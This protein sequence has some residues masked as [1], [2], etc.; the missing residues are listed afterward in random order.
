MGLCGLGVMLGYQYRLSIGLFTVLWTITY[1]MQKSAY[2]NH[3]YLL[4]I[5]SFLMV[6]QFLTYAEY[7]LEFYVLYINSRKLHVLY[8]VDTAQ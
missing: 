2:N 6:Y 1:L 7:A 4:F 8:P 3:Y 5:L